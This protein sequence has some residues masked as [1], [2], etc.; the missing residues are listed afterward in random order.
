[1]NTEA[2]SKTLAILGYHHIG[3]PSCGQSRTRWYLAEHQFAR[4]LSLL[5][6]AGWNVISAATLLRGLNEPEAIPPRA[7]L[8]TFDDCHR[9]LIET[10][11]PLLCRFGFPAVAFAP[12]DYIGRDNSYDAEYAP[13]EPLC[14]WDDLRQLDAAGVSIQSH[15][16]SHR[17]LSWL[18]PAEQEEELSRSREA[19]EQAVGKTV[20]LFAYPYG[21]AGVDPLWLRELFRRTGYQAAC[22]FGG[23]PNRVPLVHPYH[24]ERIAIEPTTDLT[25]ALEPLREP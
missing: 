13:R 8:L 5:R 23:G 22:L 25:V 9:S 10:A 15:S 6:D 19:L 11:L 12:T 7:V 16:T 2:G 20:H 14:S 17:G 24:L 3:E 18:A 4:H 21:D 1:M